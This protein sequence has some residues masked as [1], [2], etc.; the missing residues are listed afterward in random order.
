MSLA[1]LQS[2]FKKGKIT[3]QEYIHKMHK[4]HG[5][6]FE[7]TDFI[8]NTDIAKIEVQ[9]DLL[10]FTSRANKVKMIVDSKDKRTTP[11]EIL[12]FGA[13]EK[14]DFPM[15]LQLIDKGDIVFD[16]GANIGWVSISIS[17]AKKRVKVFAFEPVKN[18]YLDLKNNI[19]LNHVT[20]IKTFN[21]GFADK[22]KELTF[23]YN[24]M[25]S[26][27]ASLKDVSMSKDVQKITCQFKK[28]DN[29]MLDVKAKIDFI[30]CDVEGAEIFVFNGGLRTIGKHKPIIFVEM[31]RKW[32]AKFKYT[33][34]DTI[35]LLK[36]LGY[37]C[38]VA[39][40]DTLVQF[41]KMDEDTIR[42]NF[43]FLHQVKHRK[44]IAQ[45]A[46]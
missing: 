20:N 46:K 9:N 23:Y 1:S 27:S 26:G 25:D 45:F 2:S 34:N 43:F 21:F 16:I 44:K 41:T 6:L 35:A 15:L 13:F 12:N 31:L 39:E 14:N 5:Y 36:K 28:L 37:N 8:K 11:V 17:K 24:P 40:G 30:K 3:K 33:P 10:I 42:T 22:E 38:Y 29:F 4:R 18:T 32:A 19:K 7:Y